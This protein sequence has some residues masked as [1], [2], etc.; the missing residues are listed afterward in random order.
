MF[1]QGAIRSAGG[2]A[3]RNAVC[4]LKIFSRIN[5]RRE[6]Q[7]GSTGTFVCFKLLGFKLEF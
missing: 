3:Q 1:L 7:N 5:V 4:L 2:T 6:P